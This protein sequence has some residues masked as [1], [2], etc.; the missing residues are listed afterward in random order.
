M[1]LLAALHLL[2]PACVGGCYSRWS[3]GRNVRVH[4]GLSGRSRVSRLFSSHKVLLVRGATS[5]SRLLC[6]TDRPWLVAV[7]TNCTCPSGCFL[8]L[9]GGRSALLWRTLD[10]VLAGGTRCTASKKPVR[11]C[12]RRSRTSKKIPAC[13]RDRSTQARVLSRSAVTTCHEVHPE[14]QS[15]GNRVLPPARIAGE[16]CKTSRKGCATE[17]W[18]EQIR[19]Q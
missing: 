17:G 11:T 2:R 12:S 4:P 15:R 18:S 10:H 16:S 9:S 13:D 8:D 7:A 3:R 19:V 6:S 5:R 1:P 14:S